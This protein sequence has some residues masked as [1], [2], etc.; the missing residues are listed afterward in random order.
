MLN[1]RL[2]TPMSL[3]AALGM[4]APAM[5]QDGGA[6]PPVAPERRAPEGP[7]SLTSADARGA[8]RTESFQ[9]NYQKAADVQSRFEQLRAELR[10]ET[11]ETRQR[12]NRARFD[13]FFV[14]R[15]A[16]RIVMEACG[17]AHHH[18]RRQGRGRFF[19]RNPLVTR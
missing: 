18:A 4:L 8:S 13:R 17:S 19:D 5:A 3:V 12:L 15:P 11:D 6:P 16:C 10:R 7:Q 2:L 14:N 1:A 9:M